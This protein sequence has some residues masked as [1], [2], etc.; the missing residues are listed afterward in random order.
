MLND[1]FL[2]LAGIFLL[3]GGVL[4]LERIVLGTHSMAGS[5]NTRWMARSTLT[6]CGGNSTA[7]EH[8]ARCGGVQGR[9]YVLESHH[10]VAAARALDCDF[11][12]AHVIEVS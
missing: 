1:F 9:Y 11:I 4:L 8:R 2:Y 3:V 7:P 12:S 5:G 10:R 6:G